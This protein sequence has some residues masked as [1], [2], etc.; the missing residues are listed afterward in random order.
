MTFNCNFH[1]RHTGEIA[2][3]LGRDGTIDVSPRFCRY[4][5]AE[6]K[7]DNKPRN[8]RRPVDKPDY[9]MK[10]DELQVTSHWQNLID[11]VRTGQRPRLPPEDRAFEEAATLVMS[12]ES[13]KQGRKV[14]WDAANERIV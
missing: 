5:G 6:W 10:P 12:V 7:D 11:A 14:T 2:Q 3:Y 9:D 8:E 1:N 13:F 4:F